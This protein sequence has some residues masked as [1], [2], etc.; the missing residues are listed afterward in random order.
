MLLQFTKLPK[1]F[2]CKGKEYPFFISLG[3]AEYPTFASNRSQLMRCADAALYEIKLHGKKWMYGLQG[4]APVR[5]PQTA[6]D[7]HSRMIS[8]TP[9]G[10]I[11]HIQSGQR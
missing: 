1:T 10:C 3:Y 2:S 7:L 8:E 9:S 6:T 4:W 5:N 11:Y